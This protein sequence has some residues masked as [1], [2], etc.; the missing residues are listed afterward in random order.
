MDDSKLTPTLLGLTMAV[1]IWLK[2]KAPP[3]KPP[4]TN[5]MA[6][7]FRPGNHFIAVVRVGIK[8]MF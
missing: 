5:P 6:V 8:A 2:T 3:P 1:W 7:P 4:T